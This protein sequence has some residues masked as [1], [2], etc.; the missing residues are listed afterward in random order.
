MRAR[1]QIGTDANKQPIIVNSRTRV[2]YDANLVRITFPDV[3]GLVLILDR[4]DVKEMVE[5]LDGAISYGGKL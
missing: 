5:H 1:Y 3:A 2:E 4:K